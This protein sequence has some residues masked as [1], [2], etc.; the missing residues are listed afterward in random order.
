MLDVSKVDIKKDQVLAQL[1]EHKGREK[2]IHIKDLVARITNSLLCG[3][4]EERKVRKLIEELRREGQWICAHP[5]AGYYLAESMSEMYAN[6]AF[7]LARADTSIAQ[8][9]AMLRREAPDLYQ[10]LGVPRPA[11]NQKKEENHAS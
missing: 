3:E 11:N 8:V 1:R 4:A 7:L 10:L 9:A 2:G 6:C 5:D